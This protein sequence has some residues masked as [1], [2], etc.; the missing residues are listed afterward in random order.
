[1]AI[2]S[3]G[4]GSAYI[5]ND[6]CNRVFCFGEQS[7]RRKGITNKGLLGKLLRRLSRAKLGFSPHK[8]VSPI[9]S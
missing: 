6:V 8:F 3:P 7:E 1:M 4:G 2:F 9:L 5:M